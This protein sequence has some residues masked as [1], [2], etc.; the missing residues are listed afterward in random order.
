MRQRTTRAAIRAFVL[1]TPSAVAVLAVATDSPSVMLL[2]SLPGAVVVY[3]LHVEHGGVIGSTPTVPAP[4]R[5]DDHRQDRTGTR[6]VRISCPEATRTGENAV[7]RHQAHHLRG[8][9]KHLEITPHRLWRQYLSHGGCIGE[10][11]INAYLH[12]SLCLPAGER[13]ILVQA[14][15]ALLHRQSHPPVPTTGLLSHLSWNEDSP[16]NRHG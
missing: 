15:N 5:M 7:G 16:E 2:F 14:I 11:E 12:D 6:L 13:D 9:L 10:L 8:A 3:V 1:I 4:S